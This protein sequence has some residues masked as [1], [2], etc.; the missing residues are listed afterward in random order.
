MNEFQEKQLEKAKQHAL[1]KN[2]ECLSTEYSGA[3][4]KMLWKCESQNHKEWHAKYNNVVSSGQWCPECGKI[5]QAKSKTNSQGLEL[6]KAH[7]ISKNG[8]CLST[9]YKHSK[10]KLLWKCESQNHK[11]WHASYSDVLNG[12]KWCPDCGTQNASEKNTN[13][14]GLEIARAH[15]LSKNGQCLSTE[16]IN[17]REKMLWKCASQ[18]HKEWHAKYRDVVNGGQWCS[19][20]SNEK[21]I[22]ES[23]VRLIFE[24]F[25]SQPFPSVKAKWN[26]NFLT[27]RCLELDGYCEM[28][29]VAFEHDGEHHSKMV[30]YNSKHEPVINALMYQKCKDYEKKQNCKRQGV[31]LVNIPILEPKDRNVFKT[32]LDNVINSCKKN[33]LDITLTYDQLITLEKQ[34]YTV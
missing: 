26:V 28:V 5:Q 4:G 31:L 27:G 16:Y 13:S 21:F 1:S 33:G 20:C 12:G 25:Y 11:E 32:F 9:E 34:F 7:A 2:G 3:H 30:S 19:E 29:K 15:A 14:Q 24:S 8:Q 6:A 18:N 10:A 17:N 22:S 23:R